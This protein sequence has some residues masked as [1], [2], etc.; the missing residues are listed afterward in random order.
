MFQLLAIFGW[1]SAGVLLNRLLPQPNL[2]KRLNQFIIWFSLPATV[3]LALHQLQWDPADLLPISM[4]WIIFVVSVVLFTLLAKKYHW[5]KQ[6]LGALVLTAGLGNT[7]FVG[8]PLLR[9]LYGERALSIAVLND[10]PGSFLVLSTLGIY[11]ACYYS[12]KQSSVLVLAKKIISFPPVWAM[13]LAA[14]LREAW[15]FLT[16]FARFLD[17]E[18]V[19]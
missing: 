14:R 6:T 2:F 16:P 17:S 4:A 1:M 11:F 7:S 15:N 9:A 13:I 19:R 12:A 10:Q 5:S 18:P 3:L 8:Y